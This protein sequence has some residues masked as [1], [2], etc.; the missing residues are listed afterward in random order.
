MVPHST[1]ETEMTVIE[2]AKAAAVV[3][4]EGYLQIYLGG[5]DDYPCGFAWVDVMPKHKGNTKD[6]K[7]ERAT[8]TEMGFKLDHTG[9]KF[10]LWNPSQIYVQNMDTKYAGAVAAANVLKEAGFNA[11]AGCRL[12]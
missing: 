4:S 5:E 10:T 3:A 12:D 11:S 7:A 9:K 2:M 6:G 8:L 1:G